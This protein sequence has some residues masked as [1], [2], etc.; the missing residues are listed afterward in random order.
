[1]RTEDVASMYERRAI[2][3][4]QESARAAEAAE[5]AERTSN[6][7]LGSGACGA[8]CASGGECESKK[9]ETGLGPKAPCPGCETHAPQHGIENP[10]NI[11]MG[12]GETPDGVG[13]HQPVMPGYPHLPPTQPQGWSWQPLF[14]GSGV[15][16]SNRPIYD[17]LTQQQPTTPIPVNPIP[18]SHTSPSTWRQAVVAGTWYGLLS[19]P[20]GWAVYEY[21]L[22][23]TTSPVHAPVLAGLPSGLGTLSQLQMALTGLQSG[24]QGDA[25]SAWYAATSAGDSFLGAGNAGDP[26]QY[27]LAVNQYKT[28]GAAAVNGASGVGAELNASDPTGTVTPY[29]TNAWNYNAQLQ[30]V[31][32]TT[33]ANGVASTQADA[34]SAQGIIGLMKA[35]YIKGAQ[36][37]ISANQPTPVKPPPG[38][39]GG[40]GGNVTPPAPTPSGTTSA[41]TTS[42]ANTILIGAGVVGASLIGYALY[43]RYY[44]KTKP[45][46]RAKTRV[47]SGR[48]AHSARTLKA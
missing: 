46:S 48:T 24:N 38:G 28:A 39:G 43:K 37:A 4:A 3:A 15:T 14:N 21:Q 45:F 47:P 34:L 5:A 8:S 16:P 1:M 12:V 2:R 32:S 42:Y 23:R 7:G 11:L 36:L 13:S 10:A 44:G 29:T 17:L 30:A 20:N 18:V 35:Q 9:V 41:G 26:T 25:A 6:C 31:N 22:A 27:D 40:G 33:S 19:A